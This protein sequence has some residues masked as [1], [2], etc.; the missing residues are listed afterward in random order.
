MT[1]SEF[2]WFIHTQL[3]QANKLNNYGYAEACEDLLALAE[4]IDS[5]D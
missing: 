4:D 2:I 1:K 3:E 5:L